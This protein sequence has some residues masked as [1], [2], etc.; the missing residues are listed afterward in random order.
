[1][2]DSEY[3]RKKIITRGCVQRAGDRDSGRRR[4]TEQTETERNQRRHTK[5]GGR[6]KNTNLASPLRWAHQESEQLHS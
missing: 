2:S 5:G 1:M 3:S 6:E 4:E